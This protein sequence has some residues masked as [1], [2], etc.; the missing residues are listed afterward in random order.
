MPNNVKG[1]IAIA[2]IVF[3]VTLSASAHTIMPTS[4][5][6]KLNMGR[7]TKF[8]TRNIPGSFGLDVDVYY[9]D[10]MTY[11]QGGFQTHTVGKASYAW[12]DFEVLVQVLVSIYNPGPNEIKGLKQAIAS[13]ANKAELSEMI[14]SGGKFIDGGIVNLRDIKVLWFEFER[15][16]SRM[17]ESSRGIYRAYMIP[18]DAGYM[19]YLQFAVSCKTGKNPTEDFRALKPMITQCAVALSL[20]DYSQ[21]DKSGSVG[22][23]THRE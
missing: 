7:L 10:C 8:N 23:K 18:A 4:E 19:L 17:G 20:K 13:V 9:P 15:T 6:A 1:A 5:I 14:P 16:A 2:W 12:N 21:F 11:E 3:F 22:V